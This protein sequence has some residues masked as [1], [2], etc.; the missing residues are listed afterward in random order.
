MQ[1]TQRQMWHQ[2]SSCLG[3]SPRAG[4]ALLNTC[5]GGFCSSP[6]NC[7]GQPLPMPSQS[8]SCTCKMLGQLLAVTPQQLGQPGQCFYPAQNIC[9]PGT[10]PALPRIELLHSFLPSMVNWASDHVLIEATCL[11]LLQTDSPSTIPVSTS[12]CC[13]CLLKLSSELGTTSLT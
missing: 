3:S 2:Q 6:H 10:V 9:N 12:L 5:S 1:Q 7:Q 8:S 13:R 4:S 11:V